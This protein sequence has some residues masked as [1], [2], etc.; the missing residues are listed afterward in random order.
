MMTTDNKLTPLDILDQC[1]QIIGQRGVDYGGIENNFTR[2]ALLVS[3]RLGRNYHPFEITTMLECVKYSRIAQTP[4][5]LDSFL[6]GINYAAFSALF[7]Q[8]YA[9]HLRGQMN[10]NTGQVSPAEVT[11]ESERGGFSGS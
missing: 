6:D 7:A 11:E 9:N 10:G 8:D 3:L 1:K 5:H 4:D 2:A